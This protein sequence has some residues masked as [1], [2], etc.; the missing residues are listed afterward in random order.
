[1][2]TQCQLREG[3]RVKNEDGNKNAAAFAWVVV[4]GSSVARVGD[5]SMMGVRAQR[6][7][8]TRG[9]VWLRRQ[10]TMRVR[11]QHATRGRDRPGGR[12]VL[13][14]PSSCPS[15]IFATW[16]TKVTSPEVVGVLAAEA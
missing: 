1:M 13:T 9:R 12:S 5:R 10:P 16:V 11:A 4:S 7:T 2:F 14:D 8:G 6:V 3:T 15:P